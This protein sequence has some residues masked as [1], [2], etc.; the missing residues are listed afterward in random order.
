MKNEAKN[1]KEKLDKDIALKELHH[2]K[3]KELQ[4]QEI[5]ACQNKLEEIL[6]KLQKGS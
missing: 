6:E 1:N 5:D 2:R 4:E 3:I